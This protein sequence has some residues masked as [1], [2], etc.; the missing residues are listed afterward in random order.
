MTEDRSKLKKYR[1]ALS[2]VRTRLL[3]EQLPDELN[4]FPRTFDSMM[5]EFG[6]RV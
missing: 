1:Q 4:Y 2:S 5:A 6:N 3:R